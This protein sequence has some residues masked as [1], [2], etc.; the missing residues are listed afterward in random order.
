MYLIILG[1]LERKM[2][3]QEQ[4]YLRTFLEKDNYGDLS[5]KTFVVLLN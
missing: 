3:L 2:N 4:K 1:C 5:N